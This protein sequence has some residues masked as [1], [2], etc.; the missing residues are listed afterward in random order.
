MALKVIW[1][2]G[3]RA[4]AMNTEKI[5][6]RSNDWLVD[7]STAGPVPRNNAKNSNEMPRLLLSED[8]PHNGLGTPRCE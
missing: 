1:R 8:K 2:T 3:Y 7:V 6:S 5:V 4:T